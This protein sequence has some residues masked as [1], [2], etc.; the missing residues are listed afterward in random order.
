MIS[1]LPS[2][3]KIRRGL[4]LG[5]TSQCSK[6]V[7]V[8]TVTTVTRMAPRQCDV[9]TSFVTFC[10][11]KGTTVTP[12]TLTK[13]LLA[14]TNST[15][16]LPIVHPHL[17]LPIL[18]PPHSLLLPFSY[19]PALVFNGQTPH[20]HDALLFYSYAAGNIKCLA[21]TRPN[22]GHLFRCGGYTR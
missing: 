14:Q 13:V 10:G 2:F 7:T 19:S 12:A 5:V 3:S 22:R 6:T 17:V 1:A 4:W 9:V 20:L 15:T 16:F 21:N 18:L 11:Q 8:T